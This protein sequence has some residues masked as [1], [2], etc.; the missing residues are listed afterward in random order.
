MTDATNARAEAA[1]C[2]I[3]RSH[4]STLLLSASATTA[5]NGLPTSSGVPS[6]PSRY[7][8]AAS[9]ILQQCQALIKDYDTMSRDLS[10]PILPVSLNTLE[11]G[12]Q[13]DREKVAQLLAIGRG[14]AEKEVS[15][16]VQAQEQER[17]TQ[18][19]TPTSEDSVEYREAS[20]YFKKK[21]NEDSRLR[22]A[23]RGAERGVRRLVR[24]LPR[25]ED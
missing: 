17:D 14:I 2:D 11:Q 16:I 3:L 12:W 18:E 8:L 10:K 21:G 6:S 20:V 24:E 4:L 15:K 22:D 7:N 1:F 25:D 5:E 13:K 9:T 23:L 19:A